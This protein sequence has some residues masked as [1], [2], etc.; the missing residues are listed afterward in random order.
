MQV[1]WI[2]V[3]AF[4]MSVVGWRNVMDMTIHFPD[5]LGKRI[6]QL[7]DGNDLVVR[8]TQVALERRV[9]AERLER[10]SQQGNQGDY[11]TDAVGAFFDKWSTHAG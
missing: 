11:A 5:E 7:P 8:A 4:A 10:S 3:G 2:Q 9:I 1:S 6:Q